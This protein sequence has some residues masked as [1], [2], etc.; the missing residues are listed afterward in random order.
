M[1]AR[2]SCYAK[3][4]AF[5]VTLTL[6]AYRAENRG[7]SSAELR[8]WR[9]VFRPRSS[10]RTPHDHAELVGSGGRARKDNAR[11]QRSSSPNS[12]THFS[13]RGMSSESP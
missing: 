9:P 1:I 7:S 6:G 13:I 11:L 5:G 2:P 8:A 12:R 3:P 10:P 4:E